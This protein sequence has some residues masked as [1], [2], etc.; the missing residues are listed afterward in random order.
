MQCLS[1]PSKLFYFGP[2][3][4][5]GPVKATNVQKL[6]D[7]DDDLLKMDFV[8]EHLRGTGNSPFI[9]LFATRS[10][11]KS[12]VDAHMG[13][14]QVIKMI[15][16]EINTSK[17]KGTM[18]CRMSDITPV[19]GAVT[20]IPMPDFLALHQIPRE[21]IKSLTLDSLS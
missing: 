11:L 18:I 16:C 9:S 3:D 15:V 17:L 10:A 1:P 19:M 5:I 4:G 13:P 2:W 20:A 6:R 21:A 12:F 8:K 14:G 7:S